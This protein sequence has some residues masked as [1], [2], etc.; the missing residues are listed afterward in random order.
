MNVSIIGLGLIGGSYGLSLKERVKGLKVFGWDQDHL[1]QLAAEKLGLVDIGC[2]SMEAAIKVADWIILALP[3]NAI[4]SNI[5]IILEALGPNQLVIDFGSTKGE[6]CR[7]VEKHSKRDQFIAAH[8]IAG[9]EYS[10]PSAAFSTLFKDKVMIVC[11][12]EKTRPIFIEAF[13]NQCAVLGMST[14]YMDA[15][16]HDN[17]LAYVSHL[18]H[19]IAFGLSTTVL[20]KEKTEIN[21]FDLAGSGFDSTVRLAKSS[22]DMWTPIF[23][24]NRSAILESLDLYLEKLHDFRQLLNDSDEQG[25]NTYL[26]RGREIRKILK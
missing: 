14:T 3:V 24:K 23:I 16:Q 15:L 25:I 10:G 9:T 6:I 1:H 5:T 13:K 4:E 12:S 26:E 8:P 18:S 22:P 20:Q 21:I 2:A 17:H 11:E 19:I 7:A